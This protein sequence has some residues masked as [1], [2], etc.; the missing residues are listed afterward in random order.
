MTALGHVQSTGSQA[1]AG[2]IDS[3]GLVGENRESMALRD[4]PNIRQNE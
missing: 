4:Y 3:K 2:T 1:I